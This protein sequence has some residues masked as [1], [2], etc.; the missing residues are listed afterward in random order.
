MMAYSFTGT[1]YITTTS[2]PVTDFPATMACWVYP[3]AAASSDT[4]LSFG[5]SST[6]RSTFSIAV[7]TGPVWSSQSIDTGGT[8]RVFN[9]SVSVQLN[10]WQFVCATMDG[11]TANS[12]VNARE[13]FVGTTRNASGITFTLNVTSTWDRF[14][15]GARRR[16][17][18]DQQFSGYISECALWNVI[19]DDNEIYSMADGI[20]PDRIRPQNLKFYSPLIRDISD[21]AS[22]TP[23]TNTNSATVIEHSRRYG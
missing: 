9:S 19:L 14:T 6:T 13:I 8:G 22:N 21:F 23:L 18:V 2:P 15:I 5:V 20:K 7:N 4:V 1:Q 3:T 11:D 10:T 12:I 16:N 17:T